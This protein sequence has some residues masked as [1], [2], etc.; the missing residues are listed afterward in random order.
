MN[1]FVQQVSLVALVGHKELSVIESKV[2]VEHQV[3]GQDGIGRVQVATHLQA[4]LVLHL[5]VVHHAEL[6]QKQVAVEQ[7]HQ[8]DQDGALTRI[9]H[10]L[11][12]GA[13]QVQVV[14]EH[15]LITVLRL[16]I[17]EDIHVT[18]VVLVGIVQAIVLQVFLVHLGARIVVDL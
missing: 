15:I 9:V 18:L 10:A 6:Q 11:Q 1:Q 5:V 2:L 16:V 4:Q 7:V 3:Q 8:Q 12:D 17:Q 14:Q 13:H